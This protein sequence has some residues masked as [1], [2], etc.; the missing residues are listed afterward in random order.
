MSAR[1]TVVRTTFAKPAPAALRTAVMFWRTR[2]VW[3]VM[4]PG[5]TFPVCGSRGICPD[6]NRRL[7]ALM[8][9]E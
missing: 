6:R 9:C 5:T 1:K 2:S 4:S 8:A 3:V 7:P